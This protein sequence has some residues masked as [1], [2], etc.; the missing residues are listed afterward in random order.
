MADRARVGVAGLGGRRP[1]PNRGANAGVSVDIG[2]QG[3]PA[4]AGYD[5]G[6]DEYYGFHLYLPL[7][8][9]N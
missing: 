7:A 2:G 8:L 4:G 5:I 3:R 9:R 1:H 6:A